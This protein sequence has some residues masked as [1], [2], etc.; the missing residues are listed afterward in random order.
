MPARSPAHIP[1]RTTCRHLAVP[2]LRENPN[3]VPQRPVPPT[4]PEL[5]AV[6]IIDNDH[7]TYQQVIDICIEA[8]GVDF[9]HAYRI[10][11]AIDNNGEAEVLHAPR[12]E[13]ERVADVIRTIGIE[14]QL[15]PTSG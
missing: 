4:G 3:A 2:L 10:A 6:V 9:D 5:F 7:N 11:L 1:G 14:V 8:L 13:A 15:R 12:A